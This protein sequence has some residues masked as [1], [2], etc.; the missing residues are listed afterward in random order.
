MPAASGGCK[1]VTGTSSGQESGVLHCFHCLTALTVEKS[2]KVVGV[3]I[4]HNATE[5]EHH[6]SERLAIVERKLGR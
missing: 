4:K 6:D 2:L 5:Q 1:E 3:L